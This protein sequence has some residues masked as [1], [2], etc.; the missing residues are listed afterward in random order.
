MSPG[1][2]S[3]GSTA[4]CLCQNARRE[5]EATQALA[6]ENTRKSGEGWAECADRLRKHDKHMVK[7]WKNEIDNLLVFAGLFSAVLTSFNIELY[8]E[9]NSKPALDQNTQVLLH[10]P[11]QSTSPT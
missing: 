3:L 10:L 4:A 8:K 5:A 6:G 2:Y 1:Y 7:A 9:L 11:A